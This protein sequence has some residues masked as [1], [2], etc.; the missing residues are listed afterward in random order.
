MAQ[1][2][3]YRW[4]CLALL[5]GL[6]A[7]A[8]MGTTHL[9]AVGVTH[10][11]DA[12]IGDLL[13]ADRDA[14]NISNAFKEAGVEH[15]YC[16]TS[17]RGADDAGFL[18]S[19]SNIMRFIDE[20]VGAQCRPNDSIVFYFSGHGFCLD[21]DA[22]LCT[23]DAKKKYL[24]QT[25]LPL[26][27]LQEMLRGTKAGQ[28]LILLDSCT[29]NFTKGMAPKLLDQP[30]ARGATFLACQLGSVAYEMGGKNDKGGAFT[31]HFIDALG[32]LR[33]KAE[34]GVS[35]QQL[36]EEVTARV[37]AWA[38][39]EN[40]TQVPQLAPENANF[41][42]IRKLGTV[43]VQ[44][45]ESVNPA[46]VTV[47]HDGVE[48][49]NAEQTHQLPVGTLTLQVKLRSQVK[50]Y[51]IDVKAEGFTPIAVVFDPPVGTIE[52]TT[53]PDKANYFIDGK[54]EG[55]GTFWQGKAP[56]G[57]RQVRLE[58][59]EPGLETVAFAIDLK[60]GAVHKEAKRFQRLQGSVTVVS[61]PPGATITEFDKPVGVAGRPL[62]LP[63]G[64]HVL[65]VSLAGYQSREVE[66]TVAPK[67]ETPKV[68]VELVPCPVKLAV[69]TA[70]AGAKVLV[71]GRD[72]Q[73]VSP[74]EVELPPGKHVVRAE[75]VG[76][77]PHQ[78]TVELLPA[79][80]LT[81]GPWN[82]PEPAPG[83]VRVTS[84][85]PGADLVVDA[86]LK[87][88]TD[89]ELEL[90]PGRHT[91]VFRLPGYVEETREIEARSEQ[92][93][94]PVHVVL[95]PRPAVL[96]VA[97]NPAGAKVTINGQPAEGDPLRRELPPGQVRVRAE[98]A[99]R[100]PAEEVATLQPGE[101]KTITLVLVKQAPG[102]IQ[103][104]SVP[105]GAQVLDGDKVLGETPLMLKREAGRYQYRV[106]LAGY[107]EATVQFVIQAKQTTP[108]VTAELEPLPVTVAF[109]TDPAG[110][111]I[112]INGEDIGRPTPC[113]HALLPGSY[114][115][116]ARRPPN[117]AVEE[118]VVVSAGQPVRWRRE[119]PAPGPVRV[120][121]ESVPS[122]AA[123]VID[124]RRG[125]ERTTAVLE[126]PIGPHT[127]GVELPGYRP[128]S[129]AITI[130]PEAV[131]AP[132]KIQLVP[133]AVSVAVAS[134]PA[135]ATV[136]VDGRDTGRKTP[137]TVDLMPGQVRLGLVLGERYAPLERVVS[138]T[139]GAA[140]ELGVL[141]LDEAVGQ[142]FVDTDPDGATVLL[143]QRTLGVTP[144][145]FPLAVGEHKLTL[146]LA[147]CREES[148][149]ATVKRGEVTRLQP[150][151][152]TLLP[153]LLV[154]ASN[155]PG[156]AVLLNGQDTGK[157]TDCKLEVPA[158][159]LKVTLQK[160]GHQSF[161]TTVRV[162]PGETVELP[163]RPL[164]KLDLPKDWPTSLPDFKAPDGTQVRVSPRDR[165]P[166]V[167]VPAGKVLLGA[168]PGDRAAAKDETGGKEV[169]LDAF[170]MDV[171]E[172]TVG[173]YLE[174]C[175]ATRRRMPAQPGTSTLRHPVVNISF[176]DAQD[177]A[178]WA[179]RRLP[180][181]AEFQRAARGAHPDWIYP[182]GAQPP[183]ATR[184]N[185]RGAADGQESLAP[186]AAFPANEFGVYDLAGN[187]GEWGSEWY[188]PDWHREAAKSNPVQGK[189]KERKVRQY[190]TPVGDIVDEPYFIPLPYRQ[191]FGGSWLDEADGLRVSNRSSR[192]PN[193]RDVAT[194]F[195]CVESVAR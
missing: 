156:A 22:Y 61:T 37:S 164:P 43:L 32:E 64:R 6:T 136:F 69:R 90:K 109:E 8:A 176:D 113:E 94:D 167:L 185:Y 194:G 76:R 105:G 141:K 29:E 1:S 133:L 4:T 192:K 111:Q 162:G 137:C 116:E 135:G 74:C 115:V 56:A 7:P 33:S 118:Q 195:R 17:E 139:A 54:L 108:A 138:V 67:T 65:G 169:T 158:G 190:T 60:E 153:G 157:R 36:A 47:L 3:R 121:V 181:E 21:N 68:T 101:E 145:T 147:G 87:G 35:L 11:A 55:T 173:Q 20:I 2:R 188:L 26:S 174:F 27:L 16:L 165:M 149:A 28:Y 104:R 48:L 31:H 58:P 5:L 59:L 24:G 150:V 106:A 12:D 130:A 89:T 155:P 75:L 163:S 126:L 186:V 66:V 170:W 100:E 125:Q 19:R 144:G 45:P 50:S 41:E 171:H 10:N 99:G 159:E 168:V 160:E 40:K 85:P 83:R 177:Y 187:V 166:Q 49:G 189:D 97:T 79:Q 112:L 73:Q 53:H 38:R 52:L 80:P 154:V 98:A 95:R 34:T 122:G 175:Q 179:G 191:V 180:T 77:L 119:L 124:G 44:C 182:W 123:V 193:W 96:L 13:Y 142:V 152:M 42:V 81:V 148:V 88:R 70:P 146:R 62:S 151:K 91:I 132:V 18:P 178:A 51:D 9:I 86:G 25:A 78:E 57:A 120:T 183:D 39:A 128:A 184:A 143:G 63:A 131:P 107:R 82:L 30:K 161:E 14:E 129:Q 127:I 71:D 23:S 103:I 134:E 72:T 93:G 117:R 46:A 15:I 92:A 84:E 102:Q 172:V 140:P 110:A 114:R